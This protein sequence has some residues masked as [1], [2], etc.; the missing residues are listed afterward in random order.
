MKKLLALILCLALV[1]PVLASCGEK[2]PV[3][4]KFE[5]ELYDKDS[6]RISDN[7]EEFNEYLDKY[8]GYRQYTSFILIY[9]SEGTDADDIDLTKLHY[10]SRGNSDGKISISIDKSSINRE[11]F[12][13]LTKD[14]RITKIY[15]DCLDIIYSDFG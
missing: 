3:F 1:L 6:V 12:I 9:L 7:E 11:A 14:E 8:I 10:K 4:T 13:D 15:F 5:F 2:E